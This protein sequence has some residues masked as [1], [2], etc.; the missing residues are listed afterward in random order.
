M[1]LRKKIDYNPYLL[2]TIQPVGGVSFSDR[3]II[4]GDGYESC[5]RIYEFKTRVD[6]YWLEDLTDLSDVIVTVDISTENQ[7]QIL[8]KL[9]RSISEQYTRIDDAVSNIDRIKASAE[10]EKLQGLVDDITQHEEV[11]KLVTIRYY[12]SALTL[13]ELDIRVKDVLESIKNKGYRGAILINEQEYEWKSLFESATNQSYFKNKRVGEPIPSIYL[14]GGYPFHFTELSDPTGM[15]LG[16]T[17]TGGNM[18]LDIFT[19]NDFRKSYNALVVGLMGAGKSTLLKKL[20][21][22]TAIVGNMVRVFDIAGE[23]RELVLELGGKVIALD[24]TDGIINLLQVFATVIDEDTNEVLEEQSYMNHLSK[25]SMIY[26]CLSPKAG[27]AELR[28][29]ERILREFYSYCGIE[30]S[31]ATT[32]KANEYPIMEELLEYIRKELYEDFNKKIVRKNISDTKRERLEYIELNVESMVKDYGKLFNGHS[33]LENFYEEQIVSFEIKNL[34]QFD[35]RVFNAQTFNIMTML[36]N[37]ALKQG[38]IAKKLYDK[39]EVSFEDSKK[40]FVLIDEAHKFINSDNLMAVDYSISFE[41]EARKYFA[42]LIFATQSIR[43]VVPENIDSEALHKIKTLF[44]L[45]QY[46]FIMQQ[47]N[48]SKESLKEIFAGQITESEIERIPSFTK[49]ECIL[50][51]NGYKNIKFNVEI[52]DKEKQLFAGGA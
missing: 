26:Q 33:T 6:D 27:Q 32:Y 12:V 47:D 24:G 16:R 28:E 43:D 1:V 45:T 34:A 2:K 42:G 18:L 40:F 31:K 25:V 38:S 35:R 29:F 10:V 37:N 4:K 49:G 22:N 46:K 5:I 11:I 36:W 13:E 50:S 39:R 17:R 9:E 48:N 7:S 8:E 52:T 51:I 20:L 41:R 30:I 44:E 14:G 23:F 15:Y 3:A 19:M 21:K